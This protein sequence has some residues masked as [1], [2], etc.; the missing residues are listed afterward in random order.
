MRSFS[1]ADAAA[2]PFEQ[3]THWW[4]E[5]IAS[6]LDEVNAMTLA[7]A[8]AQGKPSARIVLL[9]GVSREGFEF[10]TNYE[11]NKAK[12]LSENKNAALVFFW[13]E[14]ERQVRIEGTVTKASAE[15]SDAYFLSRPLQSRIGAWASPQSREI[16][17]RNLLDES[18][19]GV[20][21]K[22]A[23]K[24][25]TRPPFWGGYIVK[26][27]MMEFWQ[28]RSNRLHDRIEYNLVNGT[29]GKRRLAP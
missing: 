25:V 23:G 17:S 22:F 16:I 11:S 5:A 26:P 9:K 6:H 20:E 7:T 15:M 28:G 27:V 1:D 12:E 4:Q 8:D 14:L 3:F 29:W 19:A 10:F 18:V 24:E 13:K 21:N 2:D